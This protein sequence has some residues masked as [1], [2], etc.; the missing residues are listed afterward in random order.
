[1]CFHI[2]QITASQVYFWNQSAENLKQMHE[3]RIYPP[4]ITLTL[5]LT[6]SS[7]TK[8]VPIQ[9]CVSGA[10]NELDK[11]VLLPLHG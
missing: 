9:I 8:P 11:E 3:E 7:S 6:E 4:K 5:E 1:M 10:Q 2:I